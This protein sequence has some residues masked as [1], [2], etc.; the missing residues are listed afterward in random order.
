VGGKNKGPY[1]INIA[2]FSQLQVSNSKL[3]TVYPHFSVDEN[4]AACGCFVD[5][6]QACQKAL[7]QTTFYAQKA[8]KRPQF[9]QKPSQSLRKS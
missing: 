4:E 6:H 9:Y 1:S 3:Y 8:C 7:K 5:R 2:I